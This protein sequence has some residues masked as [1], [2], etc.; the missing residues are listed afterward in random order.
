MKRILLFAAGLLALTTSSNAQSSKMGSDL[1]LGPV[2]GMGNSWVGNMPGTNRFMPNGNIGVAAI[3]S[4]NSHWGW[5]SQLTFASEGYRID[6]MGNTYT[7][8]PLYLRLQPIRAYYFFGDVKSIVRPKIYLAPSLGI[9]LSEMDYV[10]GYHDSYM[11]GNM[12]TFRTLDFGLNAGAGVNV[13]LARGTWLNADLGYYQGLTDAV[14]GGMATNYNVNHN[15][16]LNLGV[17]FAIR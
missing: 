6:Y 11:A 15:L 7:A 4:D 1:T 10:N 16:G 8:A 12:G 13:K 14:K 5:G 2:V 17:L 3:Y 9:K